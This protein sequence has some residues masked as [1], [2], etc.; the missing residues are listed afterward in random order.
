MPRNRETYCCTVLLGIHQPVV[1]SS[2]IESISS[3]WKTTQPVAEGETKKKASLTSAAKIDV[4]PVVPLR[5]SVRAIGFVLPRR[6][7]FS[8]P[9][10]NRKGLA[11]IVLSNGG[12]LRFCQSACG[13]GDSEMAARWQRDPSFSRTDDS[14]PGAT[15]GGVT[16]CGKR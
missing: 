16:P 6:P 1:D 8:I 12:G 2:Q 7:S 14:V 11:V 9:A 10:A 3:D 5:R 4:S 15:R 13:V